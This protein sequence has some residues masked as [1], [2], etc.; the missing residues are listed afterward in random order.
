MEEV[1]FLGF[2]IKYY[3]VIIS[4]LLENICIFTFFRSFVC[5][6]F[7]RLLRFFCYFY[8]DYRFLIYVSKFLIKL[9]I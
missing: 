5:L 7:F 2:F 8:Y 1:D 9:K 6:F 3:Y 4:E